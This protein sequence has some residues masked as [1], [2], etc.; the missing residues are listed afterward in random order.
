MARVRSVKFLVLGSVKISSKKNALKSMEKKP[1]K[2]EAETYSVVSAGFCFGAEPGEGRQ[3]VLDAG[4]CGRRGANGYAFSLS[5]FL[6]QF[7]QQFVTKRV[8]FKS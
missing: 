6:F 4:A 8:L 5:I 3:Q 7:S 2:E 1:C